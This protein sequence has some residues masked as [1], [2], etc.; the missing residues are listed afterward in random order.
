M[1]SI[2]Q[3]PLPFDRIG[4]DFL[5][6]LPET[7]NGHRYILV[8]T[9]YC[10]RWTE[11]FATK[12]IK[13]ETVAKIL[14]AE[15]ICRYLAPREILSDQ[16]R[17]F[18]SKTVSEICKYF[19][20][21]KI[22]TSAY[23]PSTNGLTE[24]INDTLCKMLSV[25]VNDQQI[26]WDLYLPIVQFAYRISEQKSAK[27]SPFKLLFARD[28][29]L[30][31][32]IDKWSPNQHFLNKID[33]AWKDAKHHIEKSQ[34]YSTKLYNSKYKSTPKPIQIG[35]KIR[36]HN[37]VTKVGQKTKLRKDIWT[38]P[39]KV[40]NTNNHCNNKKCNDKPV[41]IHKNRIKPAE[42]PRT[43]YITRYGR[44]TKKINYTN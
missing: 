32:E 20:I 37:L 4:I 25:Y 38:G 23:H 1:H 24:K 42:I 15:I 13:A 11:A 34:E 33:Q 40:Q 21:N 29:R 18:L 36:V 39:Y 3:P 5:G 26:N 10:T 35:D 28:A 6:P 7:E 8:I 17:N 12:N 30:P 16:S 31:S 19:K 43:N 14:I 41:W 9:D 27:E 44:V 22:N 2:P